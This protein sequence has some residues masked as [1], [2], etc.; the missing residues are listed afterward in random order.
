MSHNV[1]F[2]WLERDVRDLHPATNIY[3]ARPRETV[4]QY[5]EKLNDLSGGWT[6]WSDVPKVIEKPLP[7]GNIVYSGDLTRFSELG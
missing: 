3:P 2:R 7:I 1:D 4:L 6:A 5:R